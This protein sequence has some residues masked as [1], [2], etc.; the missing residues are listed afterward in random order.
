MLL[1]IAAVLCVVSVPL[2]GGRLARL[3][4]LDLRATWAALLA[5]ALQVWI[6]Q[7]PDGSHALHVF[8]HFAS[9]A[10]VSWFLIAN[11]RLVGMPLLALG[12]ALNV[13]AISVNGGTMPAS[14]SAARIAGIDSADGFANS[15][16]VAHPHLLWLGDVIPV[17]GP[18]PIGNVLSVGDLLI[19]AGALYLLHRTCESRLA[20]GREPTPADS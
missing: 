8:L 13:L 6:T 10:F 3:A 12:A 14:V 17:P 7:A 18:W 1:V 4:E 19:F 5:A 16:A 20:L 9:Y 11:R 15:A 2:F